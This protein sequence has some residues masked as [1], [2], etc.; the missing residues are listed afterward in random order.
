M[1]ALFLRL[2]WRF[3]LFGLFLVG[4]T[5]EEENERGSDDEENSSDDVVPCLDRILQIFRIDITVEEHGD[6]GTDDQTKDRIESRDPML[7]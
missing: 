2:L 5:Q 4:K 3:S 6:E 7:F 1:S